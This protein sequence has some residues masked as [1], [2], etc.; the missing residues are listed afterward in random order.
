MKRLRLFTVMIV[1]TSFALLGLPITAQ[2]LMIPL[3]A[4]S[5]QMLGQAE[6]GGIALADLD[7]DGDLDIFAANYGPNQVW[8]N[9]G[10]GVFTN[11]GLNYG[12][13]SSKD[14]SSVSI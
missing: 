9:N 5:G 8:L 2:T 11:S 12:N 1:A 7:G 3:F 13:S 6:T 4:P 10:Q 14:V